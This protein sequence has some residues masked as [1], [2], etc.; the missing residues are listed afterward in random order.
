M[1]GQVALVSTQS[2]TLRHQDANLK[3]LGRQSPATGQR[4]QALRWAALCSE[5]GPGG[6]GRGRSRRGKAPQ[7][8]VRAPGP[9][10]PHPLPALHESCVMTQMQTAPEA[11]RDSQQHAWAQTTV[12]PAPLPRF[13]KPQATLSVGR[14]PRIP[15]PE[16]ERHLLAP[17][18]AWLPGGQARGPPDKAPRYCRQAAL[19]PA[20]DT[21]AL[22]AGQGQR[23]GPMFHA[24]PRGQPKSAAHIV[25]VPQPHTHTPAMSRVT[26]GAM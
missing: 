14:T 21:T 7:Q 13:P 23:L 1:D 8:H 4:G 6:R 24:L 5:R 16:G 18:T 26:P 2:L 25:P 9:P 17:T 3:L 15:L 22:P 19:C 12:R 11:P 10:T 20:N